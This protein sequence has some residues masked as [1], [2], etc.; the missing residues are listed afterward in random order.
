MGEHSRGRGSTLSSGVAVVVVLAAVSTFFNVSDLPSSWFLQNNVG[1]QSK[2]EYN[3]STWALP[4]ETF[5][6]LS[7][8]TGTGL[9]AGEPPDPNAVL[10]NLSHPFPSPSITIVLNECTPS[11]NQALVKDVSFPQYG[12]AS[13]YFSKD[14]TFP[15]DTFVVCRLH[16][17]GK[18][19]FP[20]VMQQLYGC[21]SYWQ[22][23]IHE[24]IQPKRTPVLLVPPVMR[25]K[26]EHNPFL[27]GFIEVM[28]SQLGV[29]VIIDDGGQNHLDTI[30][31]SHNRNVTTMSLNQSLSLLSTNATLVAQEFGLSGG[32]ILSHAKEMNQLVLQHYHSNSTIPVIN[33]AGISSS[34]KSFNAT[35]A[36]LPR[37]GILNR[38]PSNGRFL[39]NAESLRDSLVEALFKNRSD[40]AY[41]IHI[42]FFEGRTFQEQ[43][44][45]FQNTDI[46]ISP[47]GAQLT[48]IPFLANNNSCS[49]VLELFPKRYWIPSFFGSLARN[50]GVNYSYLYLSENPPEGEQAT[51]L[52][53]RV[54]AR[55]QSLCPNPLEIIAA[56]T[57]LVNDWQQCCN[58]LIK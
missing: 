4:N 2:N 34:K 3:T 30:M 45:F 23:K 10:S 28:T 51:S 5:K 24:T 47:H 50:A 32:Y 49:Q 7:S 12:N 31:E 1:I 8:P 19:H 25:G 14:V 33:D 39:S 29:K 40:A 22:E 26:L 55:A 6:N 48:G 13:L 35:K 43:V 36:T 18:S 38:K 16:P 17:V 9:P 52:R 57:D 42:Y 53:E 20:H 41:S 56:V 46:V 15:N 44:E 54:R 58:S 37:I 11:S 27:K 21:Y